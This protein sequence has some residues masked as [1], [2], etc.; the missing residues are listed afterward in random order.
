MPAARC[1]S[2]NLIG[3]F[4][5]PETWHYGLVFSEPAADF[6]LAL[7]LRRRRKVSIDLAAPGRCGWPTPVML[8]FPGFR[9]ILVVP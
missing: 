2:L 9:A 5:M 6:I 7:P 8:D 1:R 3:G 4:R